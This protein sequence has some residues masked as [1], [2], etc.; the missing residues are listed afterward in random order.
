MKEF[1]FG[2]ITEFAAGILFM[3]V[4]ILFITRNNF[5]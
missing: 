2:N 4:L 3:I 5:R 1:I